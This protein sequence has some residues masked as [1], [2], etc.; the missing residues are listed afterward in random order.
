MISE[1]YVGWAMPTKTRIW[2]AMPTLHLRLKCTGFFQESNRIPIVRHCERSK[3]IAKTEI[4]TLHFVP[5]AM[6]SYI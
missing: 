1:I 5:L 2:W 4:A 3:A 6:T